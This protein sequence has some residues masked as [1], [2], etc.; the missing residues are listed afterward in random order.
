[1]VVLQDEPDEQEECSYQ[2]PRSDPG[3]RCILAG[4]GSSLQGCTNQGSV[5][6]EGTGEPHHINYLCCEDLYKG[7]RE[8]PCSPTQDGSV[9]CQSHGGIR[10]H[11]PTMS[12]LAIQLWRWCLEKNLF[13][14]AEYLP[15]VDNCT[16]NEV[17]SVISRMAAALQSIPT[18]NSN[19]WGVYNR[20][21]LPH[22]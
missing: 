13:L 7:P 5:V 10:T 18:D 6:T 16:A 1:M 11:S 9:L 15:G 14:S 20:S 17:N 19:I 4:L 3:H 2:G 8:C 12:R 22:D 21:L